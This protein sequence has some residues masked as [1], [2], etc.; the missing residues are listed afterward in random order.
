MRN[1]AALFS[2]LMPG[3][4][5]IYNKQF[6][7]GIAFLV[8][9]HFDN[10]TGNINKAI[11]L[12]LNGFHHQAL[13]SVMY[14]GMLFYPGFYVYAVWDAWYYA[15]MGANKVLTTIPF[16]IGGFLGEFGAIFARKLPIP[17]LTVGLLM[18][19]PSI[20]GMVIFRKQ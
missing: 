12:D 17:A 8:I 14:D 7:K 19:I 18:I 2:L 6:I 5:Q 16:L 3:F 11:Q 20:V 15:K 10:W 4:G 9:E 13:E 1:I